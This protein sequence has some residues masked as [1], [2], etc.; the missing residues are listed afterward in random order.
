M[1]EMSKEIA[2][3]CINGNRRDALNALCNMQINILKEAEMPTKQKLDWC[4]QINKMIKDA[5]VLENG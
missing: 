4:D 5:I 3:I 2:K 1:Q